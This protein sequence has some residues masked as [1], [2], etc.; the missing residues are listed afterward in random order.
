MKNDTREENEQ[1]AACLRTLNQILTGDAR[2]LAKEIP[3]NSI[4]LVFSDPPYLEQYLPLYDWLAEE[5]ARVLKPGGFLLTY[6]GSVWKYRNMLQLGSHLTYFTDLIALHSGREC[7]ILW[8]QRLIFRH[9]SILAFSKG[10]AVPRCQVLTTWRGGGKDKRFH[11]WGQDESTARYFIDCFSGP[12]DVIWDPFVG[13]GTTLAVCK[14]INRNFIGYEI[15]PMQAEI[16]RK[17]LEIVQPFLMHMEETQAT[18]F[19]EVAV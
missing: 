13:G 3:D 19:D 16:A 2:E 9:K 17:R 14:Q 7:S 11:H 10:K 5:S 1:R 8:Q 12:G 6:V 18:L 15:D 4:D